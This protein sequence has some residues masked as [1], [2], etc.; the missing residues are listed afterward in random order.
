MEYFK[1]GTVIDSHKL[2]GTM[3]IITS[4]YFTKDRFVQGKKVYFSKK[5]GVFTVVSYAKGG[6]VDYLKVEEITTPEEALALKGSEIFID[7]DDAELPDG[8]YHF[9][10]LEKCEVYDE[11][12]E[13]IG[14]VKN[15]EEFPAQITLRVT[16]LNKKET[17]IPFIDVFIKEV[18]I[19][20]HKIKVHVIE[21]ML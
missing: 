19:K 17:F 2:D 4:T 18:D 20:N 10:E 12:D 21:G 14:R 7:K 8:Y 16:L 3:K 15:V 5:D 13:L 9:H 1:V 6:K 11:N